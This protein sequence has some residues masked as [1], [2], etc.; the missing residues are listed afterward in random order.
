MDSEVSHSY[1]FGPFYLDPSRR[2]FL[3][4]GK[5]VSLTPKAFDTLLCL[6][7]NREHVVEKADLLKSVWP[8]TFVG[9]ATLSQNVFKLRKILGQDPDGHSYIVT[10][11]KR[12]YQFVGKVSYSEDQPANG[13]DEQPATVTL[14][15]G[16]EE[17]T[18]EN[19]VKSLAIMP[20]VNMSSDPNGEYLSEGITESTI[21]NLSQLHEL[22]VVARS[23]VFRYKGRE[24]DPLE[25]GQKLNVDYVM[26]GRV[27]MRGDQLIAKAELVDVSNGWQLWG[28]QYIY[29]F[30]D[31][32]KFE[33]KIAKDISE[34]LRLSLTRK[35]RE[36]L[37]RHYT[38]NP[39]AYDLYLQG[40]YHWNQKTEEGLRKAID[41]FEQAIKTDPHYTL[42]LF[43]LAD[44]YVAFDFRGL[45][46]PKETMP[47]AKAAASKAIEIDINLAQPHASLGCVKLIYDRDWDGAKK[48]FKLA[49]KLNPK[50]GYGHN[51][52]SQYL[53]AMGQSEKSFQESRIAMDL[54]PFDPGTN[55]LLGWH[56]LHVRDYDRAIEQLKKL[57]ELEPEFFLAHL[58]L[59]LAYEQSGNFSKAVEE[60]Q[61]A[62]SLEDSP[63]SLGFLGYTF[64]ALGDRDKAEEILD[65][66]RERSKDSYVPAYSIALIHSQLGEHGQAFEHLHQALRERNQWLSWLKVAP[67]FDSLR[68]DPRF[69]ELVQRANLDQ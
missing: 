26:V 51:W 20:L 2:L 36:Q 30:S 16:A 17:T 68:L 5:P 28:Q 45:L 6:V 53:M 56:Y 40:R 32:F 60:F 52:Y 57:I 59:G 22:R 35:E 58:L 65:E 63:L 44:A 13:E 46:P 11:P 15:P 27:L 29:D 8:D 34:K 4:E 64:A 55:L 38:E 25:V 10:V 21:N 42:A 41:C 9:E 24:I 7:E 54:D 1:Q 19:H 50:Y 43:S 39:E 14:S 61:T 48:E 62:N 12:G 23:I 66:L 67:E 31:I 18:S 69:A 47:R 3:R 37:D 33:E 49:L